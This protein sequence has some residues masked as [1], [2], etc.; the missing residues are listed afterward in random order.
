MLAAGLD[1]R[2]ASERTEKAE[3]A[4]RSEAWTEDCILRVLRCRAEEN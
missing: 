4:L 1:D 2:A 3:D